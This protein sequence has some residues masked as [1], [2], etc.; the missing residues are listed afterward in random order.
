MMLYNR[1]ISENEMKQIYDAFRG[2]FI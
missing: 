2:R 1:A